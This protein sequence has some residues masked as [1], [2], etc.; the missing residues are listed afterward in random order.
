LFL[1][2]GSAFDLNGGTY[3]RAV[4]GDSLPAGDYKVVLAVRPDSPADAPLIV[5]PAGKISLP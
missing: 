5:L 3:N 2:P 4:I 1:P